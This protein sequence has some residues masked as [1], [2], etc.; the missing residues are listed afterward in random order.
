MESAHHIKVFPRSAD[1]ELPVG[2]RELS[3]ST[4]R[5]ER[6]HPETA[7]FLSNRFRRMMLTTHFPSLGPE[8]RGVLTISG[9]MADF[10]A[11][12]ATVEEL[13]AQADEALLAAKRSG[14]NRIYLVGQPEN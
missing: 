9:G 4:S 6:S 5:A 13:L 7:L 1:E 11:D 2:E 14:K 10:P 12:G 3:P 8:A